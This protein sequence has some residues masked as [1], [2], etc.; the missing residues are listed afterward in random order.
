MRTTYSVRYAPEAGYVNVNAPGATFVWGREGHGI[1]HW[2]AHGIRRGPS[3]RDTAGPRVLI[4][5]DSIT[6]ALQV[7]DEVS[8]VSQAEMRLRREPR[9]VVLN[10]GHST[11]SVADY[12]FHAPRNLETFAPRWTVVVADASD[13]TYNAWDK[14]KPRFAA[15]PDGALRVEYVDAE[16]P[17]ERRFG[18][19]TPFTK[20]VP[21]AFIR[22]REFRAAAGKEPPLFRAGRDAAA[23]SSATEP[24][25]PI[26]EEAAMLGR[27]YAGRLSVLLLPKFDVSPPFVALTPIEQR[28][29]AGLLAAGVRVV[30]PEAEFRA[31]GRQKKCPYGFANLVFNEGHLN[32]DGH[33][34][35]AE[36]LA[37]EI[38]D[39]VF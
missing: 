39:A 14:T 4:L 25:Y 16:S 27:A 11:F 15:S 2:E 26:E 33:A 17:T 12:I 20:A 13:F 37:R 21:Y 28:I 8:F 1:S 32:A 3:P 30:V 38:D 31:L 24:D 22:F 18:R 23:A 6:E 10:A 35:V 5:G 34:A 36:A 7:G 9:P 29:R 19:F